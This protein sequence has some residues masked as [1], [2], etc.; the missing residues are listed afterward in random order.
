MRTL[1]S[2]ATAAIVAVT[3]RAAAAEPRT[4]VVVIMVDDLEEDSMQV[5]LDHDLVPNI[6]RDLFDRGVVFRRSFV[7]NA[8]CCPSRA[9]FL[10]GQ[11]SHNNGVLTG[12]GRDPEGGVD[13]LDDTSTLATWLQG[14]GYRTGLIGK[15]LNGYGIDRL[16]EVPQF[17]PTYVPPG[18]DH[19]QATVG[20]T[21]YNTFEYRIND[22]VDGVTEIV[23][24]GS[25]PEEY[26]TT[27]LAGRADAFIRD[28]E[29]RD[30]D[31]P[32]F[33]VVNPLAPHGEGKR[34]R[35]RRWSWYLNPDPMDLVEKKEQMALIAKLTPPGFDKPSF[36]YTDP[37][38]PTWL[39]NAGSEPLTEIQRADMTSYYRDRL[40]SMLAVDDLVGTVMAALRETG[41]LDHTVV[42]FTSD[43][44]FLFGEHRLH[45]K[46]V[47]FD[48]STRVPLVIR[49]P[50][51]RT[52]AVDKLVV[53][54]DLAPTITELTGVQAGLPLDGRSL[55]PLLGNASDLRWRCR[56]LLEHWGEFP[57]IPTYAGLRTSRYLYVEYENEARDRELYDLT[58]DPFQTDNVSQ[59]AEYQDVAAMLARK[60]ERLRGCSGDLCRLEES[61]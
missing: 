44:G 40:A 42:I 28:A 20:A 33:L 22:T 8:L 52:A 5:L 43:N 58:Q 23:R 53:N 19:W 15:Y 17:H 24:Y 21:T 6:E 39:R 54:A 46:V 31:Q 51:A 12:K 1:L 59:A 27:V 47:A 50:D 11:Y 41:E 45:S 36:D 35:E 30:D 18:W 34:D 26:Q 32:F 2:I 9:T 25:N 4:N 49:M 56:I 29:R 61:R 55:V 38:A 14:A 16:S 48:E 60:L 37:L 3:A 13:A 10:T 57:R 7:S